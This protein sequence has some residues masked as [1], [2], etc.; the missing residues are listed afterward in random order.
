MLTDYASYRSVEA[1]VHI[2]DAYR[3]TN[4]DSLKWSPPAIIKRLDEPGMTV[5]KV[6][7]ACQTEIEPFLDIRSK[8]LL[9]E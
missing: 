1:A 4:P 2:I 9:Y 3:K 6:I 8:Y 7:E 5:D